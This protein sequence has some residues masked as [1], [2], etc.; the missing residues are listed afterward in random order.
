M[1]NLLLLFL[2]PFALSAEDA[3]DKAPELK[4]AAEAKKIKL[5]KE[6]EACKKVWNEFIKAVKAGEK[7]KAIK[8]CSGEFKKMITMVFDEKKADLQEEMKALKFIF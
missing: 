3:A 7:D 4:A 1:K 5:G 2:I 8:C 6:G